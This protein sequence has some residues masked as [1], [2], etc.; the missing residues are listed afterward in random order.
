MAADTGHA[1]DRRRARLR[2]LCE[3]LQRVDP[4]IVDVIQFGS[5]VYAPDLARDVDLVVTTRRRKDE[6]VYWDVFSD[7]GLCVDVVVRTPGEPV[8][9]ELAASVCLFGEVLLGDGGTI[10]EMER[11]M[12]VPTFERARKS[13]KTA[14]TNVRAAQKTG[15]LILKDEYF[16]VAF[17]RLFD[18]ARYAVMAFL[19]TE[20]ARWGRLRKALPAPFNRRFRE[21]INTLH[22]Q[23]SYDGNYPKDDPGAAFA[24]WRRRVEAFIDELE[25]AAKSR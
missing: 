22:I 3:V 6:D 15:D 14:L 4:D 21:I 19:H 9:G 7:E 10:K 24:D 2:A 5:S 1:V 20:D 25:Q 11:Y 18:A 13:L 23:Y 12:A 8:G 17:N 16:R